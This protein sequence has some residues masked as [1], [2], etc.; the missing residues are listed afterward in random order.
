MQKYLGLAAILNLI[1]YAYPYSQAISSPNLTPGSIPSTSGQPTGNN[2]SKYN[3][4]LPIEPNNQNMPQQNT[5]SNN[6]TSAPISSSNTNSTQV[7][8]TNNP[9]AKESAPLT[10]NAESA[11][12]KAKINS[13]ASKSKNN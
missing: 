6:D 13:S 7:E 3:N 11:N 2:V 8:S 12:Q 9:P 10:N 4:T 5:Y 1:S